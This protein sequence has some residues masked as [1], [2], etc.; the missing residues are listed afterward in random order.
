MKKLTTLVCAALLAGFTQV[1][2][3]EYY[4]FSLDLASTTAVYYNGSSLSNQGLAV[5]SD[6]TVSLTDNSDEALAFLTDTWHDASHGCTGVTL[7]V[8]L[9]GKTYINI[10][11]CQYGTGTV[12]ITD[13]SGNKVVDDLNSNDG[14]CYHQN[15]ST[16]FVT[17]VYKGEAGWITI[18]C[19]NYVPYISLQYESPIKEKA[20][21]S[22]NFMNWDALSAST[23][24][25]QVTKATKY[26][27]GDLTFSI[28]NTAVNPA[29]SN[30]KFKSGETLGWLQAAKAADPYVTTSALASI[31]K[32]RYVHAATGSNRGWKL[33]AKGDGDDDWVTISETVA[34]P[35][36][37]CEVTA[38]VNR[39]NCQLRWTNL[40]SAQNAYMF[41]LDIYGMV[42]VSQSPSLA[43]ITV[44]DSVFEA[45]DY[46]IEDEDGNY[47]GT[48]EISKTQTMVSASNPVTVEEENGE[49]GEITYNATSSDTTVVTIPVTVSG[50]TVTYTVYVVNKP[51]Y[52]LTYFDSDGTT[53]IGTQTVEKDAAITAFAYNESN[54]TVADGYKFRG[55]AVSTGDNDQQKYSVDD[56]VTSDLSLY[57]MVTD[58]ETANDSASY[59]FNLAQAHFDPADHEG[60]TITGKAYYY[61]NHGWLMYDG[62][63]ISLLCGGTGYITLGLCQYGGSCTITLKDPDGNEVGTFTAPVESDGSTQSLTLEG[64]TAGTYTLSFSGGTYLH[65]IKVVNLKGTPYTKN[66]QWYVIEAGDAE[67]LINTL[68]I[69]SSNNSSSSAERSFIFLPDGTYDLGNAC[70]TGISGY[71]ISLVGQSMDN[72]IIC[73]T[74]LQEGINVTATILNSSKELYMQD[75]TLKSNWDYDGSTGRTVC[76]QDN[77]N[78]TIAKNVKLLSYQDTYYSHTGDF[79]WETSEIHGVVD[80]LCGGGDVYYNECTLVNE[81]VNGKAATMTA[82]APGDADEWG[83]VF[84]SCTVESPVKF[85]YG[86]A[87]NGKAKLTYLNTVLNQPANLADSRFTLGGMNVVAY[88][89]NEYNTLDSTGTVVSPSEFTC[90]FYLKDEKNSQQ[91][92]LTDEEAA[93]YSYANIFNQGWDPKELCVQVTASEATYNDTTKTVSCETVDGAIAYAFFGDGKFVGLYVIGTD[94]NE[95]SITVDGTASEYTVRAANSMGGFGEEVSAVTGINKLN[96]EA[97]IVSS[98]YYNLNG[99]QVG[100][101][102]NGT[103]VKVNT[104][105]NG[106]T[107]AVK[108]AK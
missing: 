31:T 108:V 66:G 94:G 96:T 54:V 29:G 59:F 1:K 25:T 78:H 89:F 73:N 103:K 75:L 42:D 37:W 15:T 40:N 85:N 86:R 2:A 52:T 46:C 5:A 35:A 47:T 13:E 33:E 48:I 53:Q 87:W 91:V 3:V 76:L 97:G 6:G 56:I 20:I 36:G 95:P 67:G 64:L 12:T 14:T 28:Y 32:V 39:T 93:N 34:S 61:N 45:P 88:D 84:E 16:N 50:S 4:D 10:G 68:G 18:A 55:W 72:T 79:Y 100:A 106:Q 58:I 19:S 23:T 99:I 70:L 27:Q 69:V 8:Y 82:P 22:T 90:D 51:D 21:Y 107:K 92:I 102:Y 105:K 104:Y 17:G 83:Y 24:E 49:A 65:N 43:T 71:N 62:D 57:A 44:N 30:A 9:K 7:K 80:Y 101:A 41:E 11:T 98:K 26:A 81:D 74:P 63:E 77:G 38:E 60:C